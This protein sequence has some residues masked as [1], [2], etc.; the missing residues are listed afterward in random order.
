MLLVATVVHF[1]PSLEPYNYLVWMMRG[2]SALFLA[3]GALRCMRY[4]RITG[5]IE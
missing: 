5:V 1:T 2:I 3:N 4:L